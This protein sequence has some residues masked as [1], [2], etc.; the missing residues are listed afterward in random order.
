LPSPKTGNIYIA[1]RG[2]G[3]Q[4][5]GRAGHLA[6]GRHRKRASAPCWQPALTLWRF[7]YL[8]W[9]NPAELVSAWL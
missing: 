5:R 7:V 2:T 9:W 3:G 8:R 4:D 1:S 6:P